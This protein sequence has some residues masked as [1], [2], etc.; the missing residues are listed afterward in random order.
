MSPDD[1]NGSGAVPFQDVIDPF[2]RVCPGPALAV[3]ALRA[4][5]YQPIEGIPGL[6]PGP[7]GDG[8]DRTSNGRKPAH[9]HRLGDVA[10]AVSCTADHLSRVARR[11]GFSI[12]VAIRWT[13]V[14]QGL[15][16]REEG[17]SQTQIARRLGLADAPSWSRFVKNLTGKT[18]T[19]LP[20]LPLSDWVLEARRRVFLTPYQV[21]HEPETVSRSGKAG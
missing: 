21:N 12:T 8:A 9:L 11:Y 16:L 3:R 2:I 7:N 17:A 14:L 20:H 19:Q 13:T 6:E 10:N 4:V 5:A 1:H 18:P 15:A